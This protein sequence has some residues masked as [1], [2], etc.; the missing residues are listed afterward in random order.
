MSAF[1]GYE[2]VKNR[3]H[4]HCLVGAGDEH[5][6]LTSAIDKAYGLDNSEFPLTEGSSFLTLASLNEAETSGSKIYA[7]LKGVGFAFDDR[8]DGFSNE[9]LEASID[10]ALDRAGTTKDEINF[11]FY[12]NDGRQKKMKNMQT[13]LSEI[14]SDNEVICFNRHT[15]YG[16]ST[17]ALNHLYL[18]AECIYSGL[19][20]PNCS[21]E[22]AASI[23]SPPLNKGLNQGLVV[24]SS[25]N[26]NFIAMVVGDV[27]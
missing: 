18:A 10:Q 8:K 23:E 2:I 7:E 24:S 20:V 12:N 17:S 26:G 3:I 6:E 4:N 21:R 1:Y 15:G 13:G 22:I 27:N 5:S 11:V 16:E 19:H 14:F 9:P 25:V